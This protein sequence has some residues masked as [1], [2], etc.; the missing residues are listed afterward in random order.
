MPGRAPGAVTPLLDH[1]HVVELL[2]RHDDH[3][4][5]RSLGRTHH[6]KLLD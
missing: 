2:A 5:P 4:F 1:T 6:S 3:F